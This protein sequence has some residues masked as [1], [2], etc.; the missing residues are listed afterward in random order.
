VSGEIWSD[1]F[2]QNIV[3]CQ[4]CEEVPMHVAA[5]RAASG[6]RFIA[7]HQTQMLHIAQALNP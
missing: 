4:A 1:E 6:E 5:I 2:L 7:D 3:N